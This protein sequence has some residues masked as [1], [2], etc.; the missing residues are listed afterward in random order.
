MMPCVLAEIESLKKAHDEAIKNQ[1]EMF[2]LKLKEERR[3]LYE[4]HVQMPN[5][6][7]IKTQNKPMITGDWN[8][9]SKTVD[10]TTKE[11]ADELKILEMDIEN[12]RL[13][14]ELRL[15]RAQ[16]LLKTHKIHKRKRCVVQ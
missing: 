8:I 12:K 3:R 13:K 6:D 7:N 10:K 9:K 15:K 11:T 4:V 14:E 16:S 1:E 5:K 2:E